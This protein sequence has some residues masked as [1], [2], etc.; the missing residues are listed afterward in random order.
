MAKK[1]EKLPE[2]PPKAEKPKAIEI[3]SVK[4]TRKTI[5]IHWRQGDSKFDLNERDNPLPAF[6]H[7]MDDLASLVPTICHLPAKYAESGL[8]VVSFKMG[9]QGGAETVTLI[10]RKDIDDAAKE[11]AF[12]TPARLLAHPATPGKYTPKLDDEDGER[13]HAAIEQAKL[14]VRGERAQGQIVFEDNDGDED[15]GE[16]DPKQGQL[17]DLPPAATKK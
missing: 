15:G 5:E 8:R 14:Y 2:Q 12:T 9:E 3:V 1:K 7:A 17:I 11:F 6:A 10:C 4:R 13:V 16:D